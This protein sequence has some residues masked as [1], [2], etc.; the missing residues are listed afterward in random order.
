MTKPASN[1]TRARSR[2]A[3]T[4]LACAMV[5][6]R[7]WIGLGRVTVLAMLCLVFWAPPGSAAAESPEVLILVS[8]HPGEV[9]SDRELAGVQQTLRQARPE[10]FPAIEYLDTKRFPGPEHLERLKDY[11]GRKYQGREPDLIIALDD[12]ALNLLLNDSATLFAGVPVVFGGINDYHPELLT[13]RPGLTGVVQAHDLAGGLELLLRLHP[14]ARRIWVIHDHTDTGRAMGDEIARLIPR[15]EDRVQ[16]EFA[17]DVPVDELLD[18]LAELQDGTLVLLLSYAVDSTG[19]I[20]DRTNLTQLISAANSVPVYATHELLLGHGILGGLL[21]DGYRHGAQVAALALRVLDGEAPAAIAVELSQSIPAFDAIQLQRFGIQLADLPPESLIINQPLSFYTLNRALVWSGVASL[22]LLGLVILILTSAL[23]RVRRAKHAL[24][25]SQDRVREQR[26]FYEIILDRVQDGIWVSDTEHRMIYV[27]P[28]MSRLAGVPVDHLLERWVLEDFPEETLLEFRPLYLDVMASLIPREY[29]IHLV[30]PS[31]REGWQSGW[32]IPMVEG[33]AFAGMICTARDVTHI[34]D[35]DVERR[36]YQAEL[37][38]IAEIRTLSLRRT[39][40]HL[41]L[42]LESSASGLYGLDL[43][44]RITF[45]NPAVSRVLGYSPEQLYGRVDHTLFHHRY[46]DGRDYP[47]RECP[48]RRTLEQGEKVSVASEVFWHA[49]G[50]P[51]PVIYSSQPMIRD[52]EILGS[53]VNF[54]DITIQKQAEAALEA[55]LAEAER[56]SQVKSVFLANMSHEIRT[57]MN[58]IVGMTHVLRRDSHDP[59]QRGRLDRMMAA[60]HYLLS[61]IND[62]LD[63]SKIEAG[64]LELEQADFELDSLLERVRDLI[65]E[66]ARAKGLELILDL[67]ETLQGGLR[68]RGDP[69]RLT[70]VLV[71]YL[72]NAVKFTAQGHVRLLGRVEE[73]RADD[74]RLRFEIQD[75]GVGIDPKDQ[76]RLFQPFAQADDSTTRRHGGTGLGLVINRRLIELMGGADGVE[77]QP[78]AGSAFWFSVRLNR[79]LTSA[80]TAREANADADLS[81][82]ESRLSARYSGARI[83]LVEDNP[84]NQEVALALLQGVG[85]EVDLADDGA[86]A[87]EKVRIR[88]YDL[89]LMD[90]QMPVMDGLEATRAIR[91]LP[92]REKTPILAMTANAFAEDRAACLA[93]GMNDHV[94]KPVEPDA[95]FTTLLN[96]LPATERPLV[97]APAPEAAA[98]PEPVLAS[99]ADLGSLAAIP[100]IDPVRGALSLGG[101]A[102]VY[103]R[104]LRTFA[105]HHGEDGARLRAS[106]RQG[107][108]ETARRLAHT[109]K[110]VT[111]NL[112]ATRLPTLA[113]D[114][115][116]GLK[117]A[118]PE[119][120]LEALIQ[121]LESELDTLIQDIGRHLPAPDA[122]PMVEVDLEPLAAVVDELAALL[123]EDDVRAARVMRDRSE[124]LRAGLGESAAELERQIDAFEY[125]AALQTL[126]QLDSAR[127]HDV[128]QS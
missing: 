76:E 26:A 99:S 88:P 120:E 56:L 38:D 109:L 25:E 15:F 55:A 65:G 111:G 35:Q 43:D 51:I 98:S 31:G 4:T 115:E 68:L 124:L 91:R 103:V 44:G 19:K 17:P 5:A 73:A 69:T 90:V 106:L 66:Q 40:D 9:W 100:G 45:A 2:H 80:P 86:Q 6:A 85:L 64:K 23:V 87:L 52:G 122:A 59:L 39:E 92:G 50:H 11:L 46:P 67:D 61:I 127:D 104:L 93:A 123:A 84:I 27:N 118:A 96:W 121:R 102:D 71:N 116:H 7:R 74:C 126:K 79:A 63:F 119:S 101:R 72:S 95:L 81:D 36:A 114:L 94:G 3:G 53:V 110:G 16:I 97:P 20:L 83:L 34:H 33:G 82:I 8:Y 47:L 28:A 78:G 89:I 75:T 77:S 49:D 108:R 125:E 57:P 10:L 42:I 29:E 14:E 70:Q 54:I 58:A 22:L 37:E 112:G 32:L 117:Q 21:L 60:A 30:T 24:A 48:I 128:S 113:A 13:R 62:I 41:R 12:S 18:R 105:A 1:D 107:E